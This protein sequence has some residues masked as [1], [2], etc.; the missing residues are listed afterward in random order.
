M[1]IIKL[2]FWFFKDLP[3]WFQVVIWQPLLW[4]LN[5][6]KVRKSLQASG[7][8]LNI[9]PAIPKKKK[10]GFIGYVGGLAVYNTP[11]VTRAYLKAKREAEIQRIRNGFGGNYRP[12]TRIKMSDRTYVVGR[13]GEYIRMQFAA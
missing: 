11:P 8:L 1:R 3:N 6:E 13:H 12:G 10:K 9:Q 2:I 7:V 5:R 4:Q